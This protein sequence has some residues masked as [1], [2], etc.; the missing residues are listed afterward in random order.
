MTALVT[1]NEK[2]WV[3]LRMSFQFGC[4]PRRPV[5]AAWMRHGSSN[6]HAFGP[7]S[8]SICFSA[9]VR[10]M[11]SFEYVYGPFSDDDD[12]DEDADRRVLDW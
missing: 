6:T 12:N 1:A 2:I 7:S 10:S 5:R 4:S 8:D 3:Y 11:A 9:V